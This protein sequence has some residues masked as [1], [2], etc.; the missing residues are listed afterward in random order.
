MIMLMPDQH[1]SAPIVTP[2]H[3]R[4]KSGKDG[5]S[6]QRHAP[7]AYRPRSISP[8][9]PGQRRRGMALRRIAVF[10]TLAAIIYF[11]QILPEGQMRPMIANFEDQSY[12]ILRSAM[13]LLRIVLALSRR[14]GLDM[15]V[16]LRLHWDTPHIPIV[17]HLMPEK[18]SART[19]FL[20]RD[21]FRHT[22][23]RLRS[24]IVDRLIDSLDIS[25]RETPN[26]ARPFI[27]WST[28]GMWGVSQ[29]SLKQSRSRNVVRAEPFSGTIMGIHNLAIVVEAMSA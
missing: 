24:S 15:L 20:D 8:R 14:D 11:F 27:R 13:P 28:I 23:R 16:P 1:A 29:W 4:G 5:N 19:T 3:D 12:L 2:D 17:L 6:P 9:R 22:T 21:C 26:Q 7:P 10:P 25:S 18:G